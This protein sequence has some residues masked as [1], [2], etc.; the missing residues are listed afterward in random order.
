MEAGLA[1]TGMNWRVALQLGRVSNLPTVWTNVIAGIALSDVEAPLAST[2]ILIAACSLFYVAGMFLNDAF[3]RDFDQRARP[4]RP[5]PSGQV[6]AATVF[7]WGAGLAA[8]GFLL[9]L[10][11]GG[12]QWPVIASGA[13]LIGVIVLYDAWHK[14]NPVGPVVM[15][16]CRFLA[17]VTVAAAVTADFPRQVIIAAATSFCYLIGLTYA[18]KQ[19]GARRIENLWPLVFLVAPLLY[20]YPIVEVS[21]WGAATW[22]ALLASTGYAVWLLHVATPPDIRRAVVVLIAGIS[23][24]DAVF[25]MG[26]GQPTLAILTAACFVLTLL[27]QRLVSGT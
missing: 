4:E 9:L 2:V 22:I 3:D 25:V 21:A 8:T 5:I 11:A 18:A 16:A 23:L 19:E 13:A 12:A 24:V 7:Y 15:G 1:A 6:G 26:Q 20:G 27:A 14:G 17:Y 10:C